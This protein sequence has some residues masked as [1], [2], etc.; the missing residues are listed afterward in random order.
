MRT[1][2]PPVDA[3]IAALGLPAGT[4]HADDNPLAS[5][6]SETAALTAT[7]PAHTRVPAAPTARTPSTAGG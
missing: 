7:E 2:V 6:S 5:G 3:L 4:A 1:T